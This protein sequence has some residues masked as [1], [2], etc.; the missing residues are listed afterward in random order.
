LQVLQSS[1]ASTD[2][3][4]VVLRGY[5]H[6]QHNLVTEISHDSLEFRLDLVDQSLVSSQLD[7]VGRG[8]S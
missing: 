1:T 7:G 4:S 6:T 8:I 5:T 3:H 2:P